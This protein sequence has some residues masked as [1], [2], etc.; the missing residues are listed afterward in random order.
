LATEQF[1]NDIGTTLSA[2]ISSTTRPVTFSVSSG[3]G[4]PSAA[5]FRVILG[6]PGSSEILLVT[7]VNGG[8]SY[9]ATTAEGSAAQTWPIGTAAAHV[10]TAGAITQLKTDVQT[11]APVWQKVTIA[12]TAVSTAA[13]TNTVTLLALAARQIVTGVVIKHN[14]AF[15]GTSITAL[16][17]TAGDSVGGTTYYSDAPFSL[18]QTVSNTTFLASNVLALG[19][20]AGSNLTASFAATGANLSALTAGSVDFIFCLATLP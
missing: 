13:T 20:F 19:S 3:A 18:T 5:Q 12:Y 4:W 6:T 14:T 1:S 16:T 2:A 8:N 17:V 11:N 9:T 10:L 7:A 15:A